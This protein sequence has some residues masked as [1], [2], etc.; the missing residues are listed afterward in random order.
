MSIL[1]TVFYDG[2]LQDSTSFEERLSQ[3]I[4]NKHSKDQ[5]SSI[6]VYSSED[7]IVCCTYSMCYS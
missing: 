2:V 7:L 5:A 1:T 3:T 4:C 6:S